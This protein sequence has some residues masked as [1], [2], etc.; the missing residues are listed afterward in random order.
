MQAADLYWAEN[1]N[2]LLSPRLQLYVEDG[3]NFLQR[4]ERLCDIITANATHPSNTSSWALFTHEFYES[5]STRLAP[6]GAFFHW[7]PFHCMTEADFKLIL[8]SFQSTFPHATLWYTGSSHSLMM[9][10]AAPFARPDLEAV[11]DRMERHS[12][13][14]FDLGSRQQVN[15]YFTLDER[16]WRAYAGSGPIATDRQVYFLPAPDQV[17]AIAHALL[18]ARSS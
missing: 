2:V 8:R 1:Y 3:R 7:L 10:T 15:D 4:T 5:V 9:G 6:E 18:I 12:T 14:S 13:A 16:Q 17:E 11:L